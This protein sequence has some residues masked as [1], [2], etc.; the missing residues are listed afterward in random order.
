MKC[1]ECGRT[2]DDD[3]GGSY[4]RAACL[5]AC[6][7]KKLREAVAADAKPDEVARLRR[8]IEQADYVGD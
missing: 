1:P 5:A 8:R 3:A 6:L 7:R 2:F 4:D